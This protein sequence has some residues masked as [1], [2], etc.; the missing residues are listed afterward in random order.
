MHAFYSLIGRAFYGLATADGHLRPEEF[1]RLKELIDSE[2]LNRDPQLDAFGSDAAHQIEI[3]FDLLAQEEADLGDVLS[4]LKV[5]KSKNPSLFTP[6]LNSLIIRTAAKIAN[7]VAGTNKSE[8]GFL[9]RLEQT[10]KH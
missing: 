3:T 7:S 1:Q 6:E 2:W 8:L 5:Y 9:H 10:L 4:D